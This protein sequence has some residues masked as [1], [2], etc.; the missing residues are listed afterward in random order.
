[1]I[2]SHTRHIRLSYNL[3][4]H[5]TLCSLENCAAHIYRRKTW[6]VC[7]ICF[8]KENSKHCY[9]AP[10]MQHKSEITQNIFW[11]LL[12]CRNFIFCNFYASAPTAPVLIISC[13][14]CSARVEKTVC[15]IV[16]FWAAGGTV[17]P[18]NAI[19]NIARLHHYIPFLTSSLHYIPPLHTVRYIPQ[20]HTITL[21]YI[22][23]VLHP[24]LHSTTAH[25]SYAP[26]FIPL[27]S[28]W[29][30]STHACPGF[31]LFDFLF[32][33]IFNTIFSYSW[34]GTAPFRQ[35]HLYCVCIML[36]GAGNY[37]PGV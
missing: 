36:S 10:N 34:P 33:N 23:A 4:D 6:L 19:G 17:E 2:P 1:M 12:I 21:H 35:L 7:N 9:V 24:I 32:S 18:Y 14:L 26:H 11:S 13:S 8:S 5:S 22:N 28:F 30:L 15:G 27:Y 31:H 25:C 37:C 3:K 20:H 29:A 16:E